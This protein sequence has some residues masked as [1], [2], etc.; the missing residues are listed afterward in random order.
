MAKLDKQYVGHFMAHTRFKT[1][2]LRMNF[3][4]ETPQICVANIT[5]QY[6]VL[7]NIS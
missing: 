7:Y 3:Y 5:M 1:L 4:G 2:Y 6:N